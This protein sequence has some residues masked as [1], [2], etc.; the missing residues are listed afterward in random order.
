M[1]LCHIWR[2]AANGPAWSWFSL[3]PRHAP[4][5]H[6]PSAQR[7]RIG[8]SS[9]SSSSQW[10]QS[11]GR[12]GHSQPPPEQ[13]LPGGQALVTAASFCW[14]LSANRAVWSRPTATPRPSCPPVWLMVLAWWGDR[15]GPCVPADSCTE[16]QV[17]AVSS[18][19]QGCS[20]SGPGGHQSQA[21]GPSW[22]E[23]SSPSHRGCVTGAR[24]AGPA[25]SAKPRSC[26]SWGRDSRS[27]ARSL[28]REQ[29]LLF[30]P[31]GVPACPLGT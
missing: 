9:H 25:P 6:P 7:S 26:F 24:P 2:R 22:S 28:G 11:L 31:E 15:E 4:G 13:W 17:G 10:G 1:W 3:A 16:V 12:A 19:C 27:L 8:G 30:C 5:S 29:A 21:W 14:Q 20:S 18:H 23:P